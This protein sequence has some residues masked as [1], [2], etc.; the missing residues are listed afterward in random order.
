M[1]RG[2]ARRGITEKDWAGRQH[3]RRYGR[4][5][6][7]LPCPLDD[8]RRSRTATQAEAELA[9]SEPKIPISGQERRCGPRVNRFAV[10]TRTAISA[11]ANQAPR[12]DGGI[13]RNRSVRQLPSARDS[14]TRAQER[15]ID[16]VGRG[17]KRGAPHL[18][19]GSAAQPNHIRTVK[20]ELLSGKF[21]VEEP[22]GV[23][24]KLSAKS[25][26]GAA[27]KKSP[28]RLHGARGEHRSLHKISAECGIEVTVRQQPA[29]QRTRT[30]VD[31]R[32]VVCHKDP[33]ICLQ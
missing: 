11:T 1:H 33:A 21:R 6:H 14:I 8:S 17:L 32:R 2:V 25:G 18:R 19:A 12:P 10:P 16:A 30:A 20:I 27:Q 23:A 4:P 24:L 3:I 31:R 9:V 13:L 5:I 29:K 26:E 28:I 7:I 15:P 22:S